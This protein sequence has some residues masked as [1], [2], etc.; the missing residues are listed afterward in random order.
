[1]ILQAQFASFGL[2]QRGHVF[3]S[4]LVK[5][6]LEHCA[7]INHGINVFTLARVLHDRGLGVGFKPIS[8]F[9]KGRTGR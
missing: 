2:E 4:Q 9:V 1:M 5:G 8:Q 7:E 6:L 3:V